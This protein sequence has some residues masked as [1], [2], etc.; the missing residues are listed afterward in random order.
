MKG[1]VKWFKG[2]YG[3]ITGEDGKDYFVHFSDIVAEG[4]KT[5]KADEAVEFDAT[6]SEKGLQAVNVVRQ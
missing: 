6:E 2:N 4:F 5:L 1:T 3:Y